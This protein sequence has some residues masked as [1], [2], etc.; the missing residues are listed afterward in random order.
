MTYNVIRPFQRV[1]AA[2]GWVL[3][4]APLPALTQS[5]LDEIIDQVHRQTIQQVAGSSGRGTPP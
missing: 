3:A 2:G 5:G 4:M 1:A